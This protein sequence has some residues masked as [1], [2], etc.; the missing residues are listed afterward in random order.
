MKYLNVRSVDGNFVLFSNQVGSGD[1]FDKVRIADKHP[2]VNSKANR[3]K[4]TASFFMV[5]HL[6]PPS[7]ETQ[8]PLRCREGMLLTCP[9]SDEC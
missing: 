2:E 1:S 3:H 9:N 8:V 4:M 6:T 5:L 7:P